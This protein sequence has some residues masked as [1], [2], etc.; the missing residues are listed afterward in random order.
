MGYLFTSLL[1]LIR[2]K[3]RSHCLSPCKRGLLTAICSLP[4]FCGA[5]I[6]EFKLGR[7]SHVAESDTDI[8]SRESV[9]LLSYDAAAPS[10]HESTAQSACH[11]RG[12]PIF[13]T[14]NKSFS[15]AYSK[16]EK[17]LCLRAFFFLFWKEKLFK[18]RRIV[19]PVWAIV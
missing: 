6:M 5:N 16:R 17:S 18:K 1:L 14:K 2:K 4:T 15:I 8:G 19:W 10:L 7:Y 11:F 3:S 13:G 12:D 9:T